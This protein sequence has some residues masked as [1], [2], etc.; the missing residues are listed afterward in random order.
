MA[1]EAATHLDNLREA[2]QTLGLHARLLTQD[3]RLPR[4]RVI[5]PKA[6][7]L[8]EIISAAPNHD[9]WLFMWSWN[10]PITEVTHLATAAERI[11]HVLAATSPNAA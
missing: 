4:L 3:D 1:T 8:S 5:N 9:Q 7:T 11:R 10:E 6:T 2:L